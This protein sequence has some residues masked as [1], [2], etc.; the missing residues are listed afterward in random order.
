MG[1]LLCMLGFEPQIGKYPVPIKALSGHVP[2]LHLFN[3]FRFRRLYECFKR[4]VLNSRRNYRFR[5]PAFIPMH[6]RQFLR[7]HF[8]AYATTGALASSLPT[9]GNSNAGRVCNLYNCD[10]CTARRIS[11][12]GDEVFIHLA[13]VSNW[14]C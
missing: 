13:C 8:W 10:H 3:P 6:I 2:H 7:S 5:T 11:T 9:Q 4:T 14:S 12:S 1:I